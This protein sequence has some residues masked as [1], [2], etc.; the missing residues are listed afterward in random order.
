MLCAGK[1]LKQELSDAIGEGA[2]FIIC[3]G[4]DVKAWLKEWENNAQEAK[5]VQIFYLP[6]PSGAANGGVEPINRIVIC[7]FFF[8]TPIRGAKPNSGKA[9]RE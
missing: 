8:M 4:N 1:W 7:Y 2:R 6:H 5:D 9:T 3:V